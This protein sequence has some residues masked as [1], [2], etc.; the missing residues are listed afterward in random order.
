[1]IIQQDQRAC[2]LRGCGDSG[3]N[4]Q[5]IYPELNEAAVLVPRE[6][7]LV[8]DVGMAIV[9]RPRFRFDQRAPRVVVSVRG[10]WFWD[11]IRANA[12]MMP[13]VDLRYRDERDHDTDGFDGRFDEEAIELVFSYNLFR[14][15]ADRARKRESYNRYHSA[16]E[17]RKPACLNVRQNVMIAFNDIMSLEEQ[18]IYLERNQ[19]SQDKTRRAYRDQF[20]LG[21][22]T[23]L[24]LLD[25]QNEHF[26]TQRSYF[27]AQAALLS[28]QVT[29]LA[30][31]GLFL[32]AMD[33][34]NLNQEK[35][36]S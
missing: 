29:T 23:L 27:S 32:A 9:C 3:E 31:M 21:Q 26:D 1:M 19:L 11:A 30:N 17:E 13:R 28:A 36:P 7:C 12:P 34:D 5:I 25:S 22:R 6:Q 8:R 10:H 20:D 35:L 4:A 14:G 15:G 18:L 33:V 16:I 24:D 2:L